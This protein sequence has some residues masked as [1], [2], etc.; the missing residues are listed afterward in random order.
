MLLHPNAKI[1]GGLSY[2]QTVNV[3][4]NASDLNSNVM[5]TESYVFYTQTPSPPSEPVVSKTIS[6][7]GGSI[8][9]GGGSIS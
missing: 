1:N 5:P 8:S 6:L 4:I 2:G 3:S 9:L 7:G